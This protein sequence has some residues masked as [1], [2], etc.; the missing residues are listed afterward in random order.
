M[1][2]L[3][4]GVLDEK[5]KR[6]LTLVAKT[7]QNLSNLA[8]FGKK[9]VYMHPVNAFITQQIP[10]MK[11]FLDHVSVKPEI[12]KNSPIEPFDSSRECAELVEV[13]SNHLEKMKQGLAGEDLLNLDVSIKLIK[14]RAAAALKAHDDMEAQYQQ[15][16]KSPQKKW[17]S[18]NV[19][20]K[21]TTTFSKSRAG[22]EQSDLHSPLSKANSAL[23]TL[24]TKKLSTRRSH[25]SVPSP[26]TSAKGSASAV[27][28]AIGSNA[29]SLHD[30]PIAE[31]MQ[32]K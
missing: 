21:I 11:A 15:V 30:S 27:G 24:Q 22:S 17:A 25:R 20:A 1:Y 6:K 9:E 7:L 26:T 3:D 4:A 32:N 28:S 8:E 18:E 31:N 29:S 2:D 19:L 14:H 10:N 12:V 13:F 16:P 23:L 5:A